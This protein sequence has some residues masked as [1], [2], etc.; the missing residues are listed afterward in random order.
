MDG[1][2]NNSS[3]SG[4]YSPPPKRARRGSVSSSVSEGR[5]SDVTEKT[6]LN[7]LINISAFSDSAF[8]L[9]Q[10]QV[11]DENCSV[12]YGSHTASIM[13]TPCKHLFHVHC[14]YQWLQTRL[15]NRTV[16]TCPVCRAELISL[17][18]KLKDLNGLL[19][20]YDG[21]YSLDIAARAVNEWNKAEACHGVLYHFV[22]LCRHN[23]QASDDL[24]Y[25]SILR[26]II[27]PVIKA[28]IIHKYKINSAVF[29]SN[30]HLVITASDD[31]TAKIYG[32]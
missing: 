16:K 14:L 17:R 32:Y 18:N 19:D 8:K 6:A 13:K 12:C 30:G 5:T 29:S 23:S 25:V 4:S 31:G 20:K 26:K 9:E 10:A 2:N 21:C 7:A 1:I 22:Q 24:Q 3:I 15:R 11:T 27:H 28:E